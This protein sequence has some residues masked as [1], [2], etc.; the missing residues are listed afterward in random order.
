MRFQKHT[1]LP[2]V[3]F[4]MI[5]A[6][7]SM[8]TGSPAANA[9]PTPSDQTCIVRGSDGQVSWFGD[10]DAEMSKLGED[11]AAVVADYPDNATGTAFCSHYEGLAV[12]L[13]SPTPALT[14]AI[15]KLEDAHPG[16]VI[17][18]HAVAHSLNELM[19]TGRNLS[20]SLGL[21]DNMVGWGPV[22]YDGSLEV[23]VKES[24]LTQK[25]RAK[26]S[27]P[28]TAKGMASPVSVSYRP[29]AE[30][31]DAATRLA[32]SPPW[33]MGG[34]LNYS[35]G[36]SGYYCSSGIPI[37]V[38]GVHTLMTAGHCRGSSFTNN[39]SVVGAQY[40]TACPG[41]ADIYGDWKLIKGSS[42]A[43]R[44]F[45]GGLSSGD[46]HPITTSRWKTLPLG[47]GM[48]TSGST[49]GQICRYKVNSTG[50]SL[51]VDGVTSNQSY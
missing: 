27:V 20:V 40:T 26:S 50:R 6:G 43:K 35:Y 39:G 22:I 21:G 24:A 25:V 1:T 37:T 11:L 12:Y 34:R 19:N 18:M 32:D 10:P 15:R 23:D 33:Y 45:S 44:V 9:S 7:L 16:A 30:G 14:T 2:L 38:N 5:A 31:E 4:G 17:E 46:S 41:N 13:S 8:G 42:Y 29:S 28:S 49:S 51:T 48:C 3:I 36:G 47:N